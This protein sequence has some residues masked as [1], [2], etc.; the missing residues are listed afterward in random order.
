MAAAAQREHIAWGGQAMDAFGRVVKTGDSEAEA[1]QAGLGD[2]PPWQRVMNYWRAVD[3]ESSRLPSTVRFGL[4]SRADRGTLQRDLLQLATR[5]LEQV[6]SEAGAGIGLSQ[7]PATTTVLAPDTLRALQV[8]LDRAAVVDT[9]WSAAF[10]SWL[11][12]AAGLGADEFAFSEAHAD[13]AA[14]AWKAGTWEAANL[15]TRTAMRAC[16][17]EQ[18]APRVGD[19]MCQARARSADLDRF[20][21]LGAALEGRAADGGSLAMHCDVVTTVDADGFEAIGGNVLQSVTSRRMTFAPGT[22]WLDAS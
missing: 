8:A 17:I 16:D 10:I 4:F 9:P 18:T 12:R 19:L 11:A 2:T 22:Q 7:A 5:P 20:E 14:A 21:Q 15:P 6:G 1:T 13:Y 3:P